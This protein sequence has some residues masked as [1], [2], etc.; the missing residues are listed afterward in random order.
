MAIKTRI[1]REQV[2][3]D[4]DDNGLMTVYYHLLEGGTFS[5]FE[6]SECKNMSNKKNQSTYRRSV[7]RKRFHLVKEEQL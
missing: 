2:S 4:I 6:I 7:N 5:L 3:Y 1:H